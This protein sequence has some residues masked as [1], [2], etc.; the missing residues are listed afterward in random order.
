MSIPVSVTGN[1]AASASTSALGSENVKAKGDIA[2]DATEVSSSQK[3]KL[4]LNASIVQASMS[5]S[6]GAKN[7]PLS[8]LFKTALTGI[9]EALQ[10][11]YGDNAIENAMGQDNSAEATANRIVSLSTGF[12]EAYKKQHP[13]DDEEGQLNKFMETIRGGFERGFKEASDILKG[14]GALGGDIGSSIDKTYAL[15]QKGYDDFAAAQLKK[16]PDSATAS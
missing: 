9:N 6:I 1:S 3:A 15:V 5:V 4:Q 2:T 10:S 13:S 14:L 12:F 11:Q 8:L 16:Q 7:E